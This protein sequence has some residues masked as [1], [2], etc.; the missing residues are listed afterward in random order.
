MVRCFPGSGR[1][2]ISRRV[3][4]KRCGDDRFGFTQRR[5]ERRVTLIRSICLVREKK[6][7]RYGLG[8]GAMNLIEDSGD[9]RARPRPLA[10]RLQV[11][12]I[13]VNVYEGVGGRWREVLT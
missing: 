11:H 5:G 6:I 4:F 12:V 10:D 13:D 2:A 9:L 7:Y 1:P 3:Q 8:P